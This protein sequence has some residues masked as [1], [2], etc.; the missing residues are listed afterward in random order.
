MRKKIVNFSLILF[1]IF[2]YIS[3]SFAST[4]ESDNGIM[5]YYLNKYHVM[6]IKGYDEMADWMIL[7]MFKEG[8][9]VQ[10]M[11]RLLGYAKYNFF[12]KHKN[13]L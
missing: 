1:L 8:W 12:P 9:I 7:C 11:W 13:I 6:D 2:S 10:W 4:T 5:K 3:T